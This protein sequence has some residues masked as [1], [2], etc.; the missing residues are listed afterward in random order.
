MKSI[1][2]LLT[3]LFLNIFFQSNAQ[4]NSDMQAMHM[5]KDFYTAYSSLDLK[6]ANKSE[7]DLLINKYFTQEGG[8]QLKKGF[9]G[10]HDIITNDCGI[11]KKSLETMTIRTISDEKALNISTG[12]TDIIKGIKN[13]YEVSYVANPHL[14]DSN[15][16]ITEPLVLINILVVKYNGVIKI[17]HVTNN[18]RLDRASK[19]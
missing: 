2:Y 5:I 1:P 7:L 8:E 19:N 9:K 4:V 12:K 3:F 13:A 11:K 6:T 17:S 18:I 10:G 14:P 16:V 15:G